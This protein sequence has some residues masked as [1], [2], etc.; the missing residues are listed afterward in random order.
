MASTTAFV[1]DVPRIYDSHMG[2]VYFDY[3]ASDQAQRLVKL[4]PRSILIV[5]C[6][7]GIDA[8]ATKTAL[9]EVE[10]IATDLNHDMLKIAGEKFGEREVE[11]Q[12][13]DAQSLPFPDNRFDAITCQF[14]MMFVP[15][16]DAAVREALRV[17]NPGGSLIV[18]VWDTLESNPASM[19][20]HRTIQDSCTADAPQFW[21]T[22]FGYNDHTEI[23]SLFERNGFMDVEVEVVTATVPVASAEDLAHGMVYGS[24][25]FGQLMEHPEIDLETLEAE[26]ARRLAEHIGPAKTTTLQAIVATGRKG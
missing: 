7:T 12:V 13:V 9:G 5:A 16:K 10:M 3:Y 26:L 2:P 11:F 17:L 23:R 8:R 25:A 18:S 15:D 22:P 20:A 6:G 21:L 24:P 19:I 1:G 4:S 14:G